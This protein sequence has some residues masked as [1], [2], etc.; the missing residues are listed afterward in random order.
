MSLWY[1]VTM[2]LDVKVLFPTIRKHEIEG[3]A[4]DSKED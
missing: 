4:I 1:L 3:N 2:L